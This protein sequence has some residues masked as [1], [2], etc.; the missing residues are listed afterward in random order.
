MI[1]D[2]P[3]TRTRVS[4][5]VGMR[6]LGGETVV[7]SGGEIQIGRGETRPT[8]PG[9]VALRRRH[10]DPPTTTP[11]SRT[12]G[13]RDGAGDQRADALSHP[14][15]V[16]ADVLTFEERKGAIAGK[17]IAWVG[18]ANNVLDL[19]GSRRRKARLPPEDRLPPELAASDQELRVGEG[20]QR[21]RRASPR[22]RTTAA[23]GCRL[24]RHRHLGFH[25]RR[26]ARAPPTC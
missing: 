14:C 8:P 26:R 25:G 3:S 4:F 21:G 17:T 10:Y 5:D 23:E 19:V 12:R 18:D 13:E 2:K 16:V 11:W 6:D 9:P 20:E 7:L 15:Q 24:H 22:R 1:F